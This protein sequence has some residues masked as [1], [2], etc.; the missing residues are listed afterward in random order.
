MPELHIIAAGSRLSVVLKARHVSFP[1]GRVERCT[2]YP[3]SFAEFVRACGKQAL[4]EGQVTPLCLG[5]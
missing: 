3:L 1:V 2:V 5:R 4:W